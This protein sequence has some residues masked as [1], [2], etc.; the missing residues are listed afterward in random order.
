MELAAAAQRVV[1]R[2]S[3]QTTPLPA[4]RVPKSRNYTLTCNLD[5]R[6]WNQAK[7]STNTAVSVRQSSG[8][9]ATSK[10]TT[11]GR[12]EP[13]TKEPSA[14][15]SA[16]I[17]M[18]TERSAE[19]QQAFAAFMDSVLPFQQDSGGV[20]MSKLVEWSGGYLMG[21]KKPTCTIEEAK[22][23]LEVLK[24]RDVVMVGDDETLFFCI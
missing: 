8:I 7:Q 16:Q 13:S 11:L 12:N 24:E 5:K 3:P 9:D 6:N 22:V 17:K 20:K 2:A 19:I 18:S 23:V 21:Q 1:L 4:A 14:A 15:A 10:A